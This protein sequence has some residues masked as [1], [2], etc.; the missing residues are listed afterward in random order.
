LEHTLKEAKQGA[1]R[2]RARY[3]KE[4]ERF[5]ESMRQRQAVAKKSGQAHIGVMM[6][7]MMMM[8]IMLMIMLMMM[9]MMMMVVAER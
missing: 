9:I 7:M 2:D 4:V 5:K 1:Q 8:M 3:Q 6:I